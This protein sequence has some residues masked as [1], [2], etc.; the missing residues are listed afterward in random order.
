MNSKV[1]TTSL[2]FMNGSL[3]T[4]KLFLLSF[5]FVVGACTN[6]DPTYDMYSTNNNKAVIDHLNTHINDKCECKGLVFSMKKHTDGCLETLNKGLC[7][8]VKYPNVSRLDFITE[9]SRHA[10]ILR[11]DG[12]G[13]FGW[14]DENKLVCTI[15]EKKEALSVFWKG[16]ALSIYQNGIP[17]IPEPAKIYTIGAN[18]SHFSKSAKDPVILNYWQ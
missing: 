2:R 7:Y 10:L 3:N 4:I 9:K 12:V 8:A 17:K 16:L 1:I 18:G 5:F 15:G 11:G 13:A 14:S 6:T